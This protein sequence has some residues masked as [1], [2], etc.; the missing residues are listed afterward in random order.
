[1]ALCHSFFPDGWLGEAGRWWLA[2]WLPILVEHVS[3]VQHQPSETR[4]TLMEQRFSLGLPWGWFQVARSADLHEKQVIPI[5]YFSKALVLFRTEQG[6]PAVLSAY[7]PHLGA[8]LGIGGSVHGE[9]VR[10]PFHAWEFDRSGSCQTIPYTTKIPKKARVRSWPVVE[11]NNLVWIWYHPNNDPPSFDVPDV[12]EAS[13]PAWSSYQHFSWKIRTC[14]QEIGENS[15]DRAHFRYVH[16]TVTVPES[17]LEVDGVFRRA[18]QEI[19]MKTPRGEVPGRIE[20]RASGMGC[21][22]TRFTGICDTVLVISH[23]PIDENY[24]Q[25]NFSFLQKKM[26]ENDPKQRVGQAIIRDIVKQMNEDIPIWENKQYLPR[27]ML[28]E[29]DGPIGQYRR[30]ARQFYLPNTEHQP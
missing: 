27:P 9:C 25:A 4:E 5:G 7:C 22:M 2:G 3:Y 11:R 14:N 18:I 23:T 1:V 21:S 19:T 20:I 28:C 13:D 26:P 29:E 17:T 16:G 8:H 10:C 6:D 12:P 30:W 15:V 24:V